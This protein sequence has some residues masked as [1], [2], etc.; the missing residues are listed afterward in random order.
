[1]LGLDPDPARLWPAAVEPGDR[2]RRP[3]RALRRTRRAR[4]RRPRSRTTAGWRSR[5]PGP[6]A[7][8]SSC[9]W[10][11]SS[12]SA[13][14]GW[15][16]LEDAVARRAR[17]R[18]AGD[19]RRQARRRPGHRRAPTRRPSSGD[20]DARSARS[21]GLGADAITANPLLG[22]DALEPL[23]GGS[24]RTRRGRLRAS[25]AR[26]TRAAPTCRTAT[27]EGRPLHEA[28]AEIADEARRAVGQRGCGPV[29]RRRGDRRDPARPARRLRELM[30][31]AIF[32]LPGRRRAGRHRRGPRAGLGQPPRGRPRHGLAL[33]RQR[34]RRR[35]A[36]SPAAAARD[37]AE[38]LRAAGLGAAR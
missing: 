37:A 23:I 33:D 9:S 14:P 12:G 16:A 19:R 20:T 15:D 17:P 25:S 38:E 36:R 8:R 5:R 28:L 7:S 29:Q 30:P 35:A 27:L 21:P 26:P 1:M 24:R 13:A 31:H 6:H 2:R 11:A 10:P 22:R 34:V 3:R 18:P 4:S 32:L